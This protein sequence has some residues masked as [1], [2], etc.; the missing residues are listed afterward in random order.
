[1]D[2]EIARDAQRLACRMVE[3]YA[4]AA[5]PPALTLRRGEHSVQRPCNETPDRTRACST[6]N[7]FTGI[8]FCS[9]PGEEERC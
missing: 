4:S 3:A 1:M 5:P 2:A 6:L 7:L 9:F 8:A